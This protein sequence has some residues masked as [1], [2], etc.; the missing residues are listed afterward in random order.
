MVKL[1][2]QSAQG[3]RIAPVRASAGV[4]AQ[5]Y[6]AMH[7]MLRRMH[8]E[9]LNDLAKAY[10]A[11]EPQIA[12]DASPLARLVKVMDQLTAKWRKRF[13][14]AADEMAKRFV[15]SAQTYT[16][17]SFQA[18][19]K[20]NGF[21]VQFK[22]TRYVQD[23]T[24]RSIAENVNLI[25]GMSDDHLKGIETAVNMSVMRGRDLSSLSEALQKQYGI[26]R[27]RAAFIARDQNNKATSVINRARQTE[28]GLKEGI[29]VHSSGGKHP[30]PDHVKAG[31]DRLRFNLT[32]GAYIGG[33]W[34]HPGEDPNCRCTWSVIIPGFDDD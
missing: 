17:S 20:R 3:K 1:R 30:R 29:W 18:E 19:L 24:S 21:T 7:A 13:D 2:C 15:K 5:Y 22:P 10:K 26:S 32:K 6:Q 12:Q 9:V 14:D 16:Q 23:M 31:K 8:K 28:L 25:K 4:E 33:R 34:I 27:R 11:A